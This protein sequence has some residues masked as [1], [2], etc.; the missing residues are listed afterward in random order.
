MI[1]NIWGVAVIRSLA[2]LQKTLVGFDLAFKWL[3]WY[4]NL[5]A[6]LWK[7]MSLIWTEKDKIMK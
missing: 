1:L 3:G 4:L 5:S 2:P 6:W 7:N